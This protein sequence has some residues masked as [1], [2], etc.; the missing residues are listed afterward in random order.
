FPG[1]YYDQETGNYYNYFRDYDPTSGRY[2]QSDPIGL[3]G[4]LNT[5]LYAEANPVRYVDPLGLNPGA[6]AIGGGVIAGPPGAVVGGILGGIVG[7]GIWD[8]LFNRN[9][10]CTASCNVQQIDPCADCP[11]RTSGTATGRSEEAACRAAKRVATQSTPRG[12]YSRHCRCVCS[13][14]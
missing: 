9:W 13:K 3:G 4:G 11:D 14:R 5:Y 2:L 1:Q 6:G 12:C 7:I 8:W 10:T